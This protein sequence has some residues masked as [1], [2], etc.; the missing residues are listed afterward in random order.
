[1]PKR[2]S[3]ED[4]GHHKRRSKRKKDNEQGLTVTQPEGRSESRTDVG[5]KSLNRDEQELQD[6]TH[7]VCRRELKL[8]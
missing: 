6:R 1:M 7:N 2:D 5:E 8:Y 3:R 4:A